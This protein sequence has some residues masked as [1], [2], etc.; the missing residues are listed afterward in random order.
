MNLVR[1]TTEN[2]NR[3][4]N[5]LTIFFENNIDSWEVF[6]P[7]ERSWAALRDIINNSIKDYY[8]IYEYETHIMGY[9]MLRGWDDGFDIPSLGI[10][11]DENW[12]G[13]GHSKTLMQHL[14]Q[15]ASDANAKKIRLTVFKENPKAISLYNSIGYDL[16]ELNEK[17]LLGIKKL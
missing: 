15:T 7:H 11:I 3:Y 8:C 1:L 2:I 5:H 16:T 4:K 6:H 12:R 17:S 10:L 14:E 9:A 13:Q